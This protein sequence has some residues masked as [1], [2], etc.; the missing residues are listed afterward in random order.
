MLVKDALA[1]Y[2]AINGF[3]TAAY[4]APTVEIP[5]GPVTI[6]LPNTAGRK[7]VVKLHDLHHLATGYGT[8]LVGEAEIG[9][10]ELRAGCV[11]LAAYVYNGMAVAMGLLIAPLR[12]VQAFRDARGTTTLY[13]LGLDY[14]AAMALDVAEL[15]ARLGVK[16]EGMAT[17]HPV[18]LHS[19]APKTSAV[20][21]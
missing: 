4:T 12:T 15:R 19:A 14:D 1:Q 10:W 18:R 3:T 17:R 16:R 6:P 5:I 20:T 11:G 13:R 9:A 7:K 2:F 21:A 8:D